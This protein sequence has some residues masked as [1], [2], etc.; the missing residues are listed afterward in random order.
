MKIHYVNC[1]QCNKSFHCDANL[2]G[3][4][5]PLHCPHCDLYFDPEEKKEEQLPK[6]IAFSGL[7]RIDRKIL[8]L[9]LQEKKSPT[10]V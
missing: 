10:K 2:L 7:S 3:L 1:P 9:P 8:Y 4:D 5:I 6:G